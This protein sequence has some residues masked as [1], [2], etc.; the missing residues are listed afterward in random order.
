MSTEVRD[1]AYK[2]TECLRSSYLKDGPSF[3]KARLWERT[4]SPGGLHQEWQRGRLASSPKV[5]LAALCLPTLHPTPGRVRRTHLWTPQS[6]AQAHPPTHT[7]GPPPGAQRA[8]SQSPLG[9]GKDPV[10]KMPAS[11][12]N[13]F[14]GKCDRGAGAPDMTCSSFLGP[15]SGATHFPDPSCTK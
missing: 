14:C 2:I 1:Q 4:L 11:S 12:V 7:P 8:V 3:W 6:S 9:G 10:A 5:Q 15:P 13:N